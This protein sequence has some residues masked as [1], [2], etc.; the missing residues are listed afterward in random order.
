MFDFSAL[1]DSKN[2]SQQL[3]QLNVLFRCAGLQ[4]QPGITRELYLKIILY[5][6]IDPQS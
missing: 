6:I 3:L 4:V 5:L 2:V 1:Y